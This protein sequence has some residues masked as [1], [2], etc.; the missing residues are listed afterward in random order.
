MLRR[1][2]SLFLNQSTNPSNSRS[3]RCCPPRQARANLFLRIFSKRKQ[4]RLGDPTAG[5]GIRRL[6]SRLGAVPSACWRRR[7]LQGLA[8]GK[9]WCARGESQL[10]GALEEPYRHGQVEPVRICRPGERSQ[11][12]A[13]GRGLAGRG[14]AKGVPPIGC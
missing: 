3:I 7:I 6:G 11:R 13:K 2:S 10:A 5:L 12:G 1:R 9:A 14:V 4:R 8:P